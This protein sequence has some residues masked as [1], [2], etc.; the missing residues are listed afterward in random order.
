M[1]A[2]GAVAGEGSPPLPAPAELR[3]VPRGA[4]PF[5]VVQQ[6][7]SGSVANVW[8]QPWQENAPLRQWNAPLRQWN[9]WLFPRCPALAELGTRDGA[10]GHSSLLPPLH[11]LL[12]LLLLCGQREPTLLVA[13]ASSLGLAWIAATIAS[14][15][16]S[17]CR[18]QK[19]HSNTAQGC[20]R[21][22]RPNRCWSPSYPK[23]T[24]P[25]EPPDP[26]VRERNQNLDPGIRTDEERLCGVKVGR[27]TRTSILASEQM[28]N[29]C[30]E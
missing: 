20:R 8:R 18:W 14:R 17:S 30:V 21:W 1:G 6:P 3:Q 28:K 4:G 16:H 24:S 10:E 23:R 29:G 22:R 13:G 12:F 9:V 2:G 5:M 19:L 25:R 7:L 11:L 27:G 15:S 26:L